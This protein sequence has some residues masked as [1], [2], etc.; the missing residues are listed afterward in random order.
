LQ[1][2]GMAHQGLVSWRGLVCFGT[3]SIEHSEAAAQRAIS[4]CQ[5]N[6]HIEARL[7]ADAYA[8]QLRLT[9]CFTMRPRPRCGWLW[10]PPAHTASCHG[11][12]R[13]CTAVQA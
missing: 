5:I 7:S 10:W 13:R 1:R 12:M 6:R 9:L 2:F 11:S 4:S 8:S 3:G